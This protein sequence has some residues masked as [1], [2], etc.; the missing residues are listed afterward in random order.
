MSESTV[1][2]LILLGISGVAATVTHCFYCRFLPAC[3]LSAFVATL[4]FQVAAFFRLGYLD[5]FFPIAVAVGGFISFV[6]ALVIGGVVRRFRSGS[7]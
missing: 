5:T 7:S 4:M 6:V 3:F 1:G 2:I